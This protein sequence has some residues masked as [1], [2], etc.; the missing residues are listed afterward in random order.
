LSVREIESDVRSDAREDDELGPT[1]RTAVVDTHRMR[2]NARRGSV[3]TTE[4]FDPCTVRD[5][6]V[7]QPPRTRVRLPRV[8]HGDRLISRRHHVRDHQVRISGGES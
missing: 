8:L 4:N 1:K 6:R 7:R 2:T 3:A 5:G